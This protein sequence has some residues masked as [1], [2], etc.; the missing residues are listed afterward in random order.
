GQGLDPAVILVASAVEANLVNTGFLGP[1][2]DDL[3]DDRGRRLVAAVGR[4]ALDLGVERAGRGQG[5]AVGVV[6]YLGV[7][8]LRAA[9]DGQPGRLGAAEEP[10]T[11]VPLP[12]QPAVLH[13]LALVLTAHGN[14]PPRGSEAA[15]CRPAAR[16]MGLI[17]RG[18]M[19]S[20]RPE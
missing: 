11:D 15:D 3:A 19:R 17:R 9:A 4:L 18:P 20:L 16:P 6:D 12:P 10:L 1:L 8:V 5:G 13:G 7:D 2:G 14:V